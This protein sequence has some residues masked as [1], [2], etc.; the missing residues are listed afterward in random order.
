LQS[1][2]QQEGFMEHVAAQE[3]NED[4]SRSTAH[5]LGYLL[6]IAALPALSSALPWRRGLV[7]A[8]LLFVVVVLM[9]QFLVMSVRSALTRGRA[10]AV[11]NWIDRAALFI[12]LASVCT[13][14]AY[15]SLGQA[16]GWRYCLGA[17]ALAAL[18]CCAH[19]LVNASRTW[20]SSTFLSSFFEP[21]Q[22]HDSK[23]HKA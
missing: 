18:G 23:V 4:F 16:D 20:D 1:D 14:V 10:K 22:E 21:L 6:S 11:I 12:G 2:I 3:S 15:D 9:R 17:W 19:G 13:V 7:V 8:T 5:A